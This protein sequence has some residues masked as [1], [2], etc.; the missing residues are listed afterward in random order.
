MKDDPKCPNCGSDIIDTTT[1]VQ[2]YNDF[3]D[4]AGY[5]CSGCKMTFSDDEIARLHKGSG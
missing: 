4:Y 5:R 1:T 2:P 3:D